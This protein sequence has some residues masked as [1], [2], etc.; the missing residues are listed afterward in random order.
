MRKIGCNKKNGM[1]VLGITRHGERGSA[2]VKNEIDT[3]EGLRHEGVMPGKDHKDGLKERERERM[4]RALGEKRNRWRERRENGG[5]N[6]Q[7]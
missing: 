6:E 5:T 1:I 2:R 4:S 3:K 7:K